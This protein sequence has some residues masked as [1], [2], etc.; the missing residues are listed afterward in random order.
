MR[1]SHPIFA[2]VY[3]LVSV[4]AERAGAA[5]HRDELLAGLR[6][7]VIEPGAGNGLNF[8]HYPAEVAEVVAVE[9]E[10]Y[11]RHRAMDAAAG[12]PVAVNVL[13]GRADE[14]PAGDHS[15]DAAVASL[16]LCTVPDQEKA[17]AELYRV[18]RPEGEL[19]FYEH[20]RADTPGRA[21]LQDRADRIWPHLGG[22]CHPNRDT[23][24]AIEAAGFVIERQRRFLFE[25]AVLAKP[26]A[27]H[28][29]GVARRP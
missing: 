21:R 29:I 8:A 6:G 18:L 22:G 28:V 16:M 20:I 23:V 27:P 26:V 12:A 1:V 11:L 7:R 15:F 14:L 17:L 19:R 25:P 13:P 24:A 10:P 9:P 5:G 4:G 3:A 2:R